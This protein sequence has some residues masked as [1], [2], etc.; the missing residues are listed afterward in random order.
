MMD[1]FITFTYTTRLYN[2]I[3]CACLECHRGLTMV[4]PNYVYTHIRTRM[5]T[6]NTHKQHTQTHTTHTQSLTQNV[7]ERLVITMVQHL[8]Y[9]E[10]EYIL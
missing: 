3:C 1:I 8:V 4:H 2:M 6:H 5:C 9:D 7:M 10:C